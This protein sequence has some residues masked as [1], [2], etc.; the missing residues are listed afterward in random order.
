MKSYAP[1]SLFR[2]FPVSK[3]DRD[4]G[5]HG[6]TAG[7][8]R[9]LPHTAYPPAGHPR[10]HMFDWTK[11]RVL[12]EY[13]LVYIASGRG[14]FECTGRRRRAIE[15]GSLLLL[16]PGVWHR[17]QPDPETGWTEYWVGFNGG[18]MRNLMRHRFFSPRHPVLKPRNEP[19][20][21]AL[22]QS[23]VAAINQDAP[24]LQQVV[25][26]ITVHLLG[27][28]FSAR[29]IGP[30]TSSGRTTRIQDAVA[31]LHRGNTRSSE[32]AQ[33]LGMSERVLRRDFK[34]HTGLS[35]HQYYLQLGIANARRLLANTSMSVKQVA[36]ECGFVDEQY[37]CRL[38]KKKT[39]LAPG[40][41]RRAEALK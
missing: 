33:Q 3:R 1:D 40:Q 16:F 5:C 29:Q 37:F 32:L 12:R 11:G 9:I 14:E 7:M 20:V 38:F 31:L 19:E 18:F 24:A 6:I 41:W 34:K 23:M 39:G 28:L 36:A 13:A 15:S 26:G 35:P 17:Y 4:W 27:L 10:G 30:E 8:A 22:F 2:Y 21:S 25:A